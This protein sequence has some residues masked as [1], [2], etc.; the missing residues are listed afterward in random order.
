MQIIQGQNIINT[1]CATTSIV[2]E[3]SFLGNEDVIS[4][5]KKTENPVLKNFKALLQASGLED[6]F[7]ELLIKN[8]EDD[9]IHNENINL[10]AFAKILARHITYGYKWRA[11]PEKIAFF[12]TSGVGKTTTI[13][14]FAYQAKLAGKNVAMIT[15]DNHKMDGARQLGK[16]GEILNIPVHLV[17]GTR[18][19]ILTFKDLQNFNLILLDTTGYNAQEIEQIMKMG[20]TLNHYNFMRASQ[21]EQIKK[22]LLLP[23]SANVYD[24]KKTINTFSI[25]KLEGLGITKTNETC[26]FGP[27]I[28]TLLQHKLPLHFVTSDRELTS[29]LTINE[30]KLSKQIINLLFNKQ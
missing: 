28:N 2:K 9:L 10:D 14:K 22:I 11:E 27:C 12:G 21:A 15:L 30:D 18:D 4:K 5:K 19:L 26:Y 20:D 24:L 1:T 7:C 3:Y 29:S 23:A 8:N 16:F 25:L 6:R 13:A 17:R